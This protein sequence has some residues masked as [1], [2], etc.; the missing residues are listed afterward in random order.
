[1]KLRAYR[2]LANLTQQALA[3]RLG[4]SELSVIK[5]EG[6]TTIPSR[7]AML[8]IYQLSGGLVTPN[9]FF[10]LENLSED[11]GK[12]SPG[13]TFVAAGL[14]SGTSMDGID[15]SLVI[16]DGEGL[17]KELGNHGIH[18]DSEMK[19]LLKTCEQ[20]CFQNDGNIENARLGFPGVL[21]QRLSKNE[22]ISEAELNSLY[23]DLCFYI[24]GK[25]DKPVLF[26]DVV[27]K[28]TDLHAAVITQLL[29]Q[30]GYNARSVDILGYHGQTLFHRPSAGIT[31]QVGNG[32]SLSDQCGI[33]VVSQFRSNDVRHGGQGAPFA[34]LYHKALAN[35]IG[36]TPVVIAN[37]GGI[38]NVT[39]IGTQDE[40]LYAYDC[41]P[42][43]AL[44]DRF[45]NFKVGRDMDRDGIYGSQGA[46]NIEVL[47]SLKKKA[48]KT[49]GDAPYLE[50]KPPKSLDVNDLTLIPE[51]EVLTLQDG[52][53]TLEAFT[54]DCIAESLVSL[55]MP[56]PKLWVLAGGGWQ[57]KKIT[58][59]LE[60]RL[61]IRLGSDVRVQHADRV[62]W[63]GQA[64]EAQIFAYL[65]V[66]SLRKMPLSLP[67][68]T[69]VPAPLTG[70][71]LA[72]PGGD[73]RKTTKRLRSFLNAIDK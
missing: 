33:A 69:G 1:M 43:C 5:Y 57:N 16:T 51:V 28:S 59:E 22:T 54:A 6:G 72:I 66:R 29:K 46:V 38:A 71:E 12:H 24:H 10:D 13:S 3:E 14:M 55:P 65:A 18:Y 45:V 36:L 34:P 56:I 7:E 4:I 35:Q 42:G 39:V 23:H 37:C 40:D 58:N 26:D 49:R 19:F 68:T 60:Q 70:G 31:M 64:M 47:K 44:I 2:A 50:R 73:P 62:G 32:Q 25:K 8:R 20:S 21:R 17:V 41:G 67:G 53:A 9:D 15:G 27:Q 30:T 63:N 61:R 52:C 48:I 11:I